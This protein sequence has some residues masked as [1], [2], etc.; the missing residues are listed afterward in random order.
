MIH[1]W[2]KTE[3]CK[4]WLLDN[5]SLTE[6]LLLKISEL[7]QNK[8][9]ISVSLAR[10]SDIKHI[11]LVSEYANSTYIF[12]LISKLRIP[13]YGLEEMIA[14]QKD[15]SCGPQGRSYSL[16]DGIYWNQPTWL[17]KIAF[18]YIWAVMCYFGETKHVHFGFPIFA[19]NYD[20]TVS[21]WSWVVAMA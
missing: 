17:G 21:N 18:R 1:L 3:L 14:S 5:N 6:V 2:I 4:T 13:Q 15:S 9:Q 11:V 19:K 20:I 12:Q 16:L 7:H 8:H 10:D